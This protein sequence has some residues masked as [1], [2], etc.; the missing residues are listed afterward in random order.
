MRKSEEIANRG[1]YRMEIPVLVEPLGNA[2]FRAR[3]GDPVPLSAEGATVDEALERLR[4]LVKTR[5]A[6]G[7]VVVPLEW[8]NGN[9][10]W[11]AFAGDLKGDPLLDEWKQAMAEY[12]RSI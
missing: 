8:P 7:A 3:L 11:L 5:A 10:P 4:D 9:H 12:R 1:D 6:Q 2:G